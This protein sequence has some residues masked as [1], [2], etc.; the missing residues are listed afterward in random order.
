MYMSDIPDNTVPYDDDG[1]PS[2][3]TWNAHVDA[4]LRQAYG[5]R[6]APRS[7]QRADCSRQHVLT[8]P[9]PGWDKR[10]CEEEMGEGHDV[11][12]VMDAYST[13]KREVRPH[14]RK[15]C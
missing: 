15:R 6:P 12:G 9:N 11:E 10:G 8:R 1:P 3:A 14:A 13:G 7:V 2:G 4:S 5:A